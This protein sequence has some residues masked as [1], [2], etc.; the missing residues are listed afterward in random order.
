[1]LFDGYIPLMAKQLDI[2]QGKV[3]NPSKYINGSSVA[4]SSI[5]FG[6]DEVDPLVIEV[7]KGLKP[8]RTI[9]DLGCG[10]ADR[11]IKVCQATG[12]PGLGL[13]DDSGA[14]RLAARLTRDNPNISVEKGDVS[15]LKG[16]W[17]DVEILMQS[18]MLHDINPE[19]EALR[20][21][22][23]YKDHFP[24]CKYLIVVDIVAI[25]DDSSVHMPGF[26]YVHGL[27]NIEPR[28]YQEVVSLFQKAGYKIKKE[29][30][31]GMPH[32]YLWIL[33]RN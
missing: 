18:F 27:Q 14:F 30:Q 12:L 24:H 8:K 17:E 13:D 11:L 28:K 32:T 19:S 10:T 16:I 33:A 31:V 2:A 5:Q 25:E 21:L 15:H 9:C 1:M 23:S 22:K 3:P 26:D 4:L 6:S 29:Y 7:I 20:M